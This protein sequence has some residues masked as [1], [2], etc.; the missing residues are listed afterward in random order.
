MKAL[1]L[2]ALTCLLTTSALAASPWDGT[3]KLDRSKSHLTGDSFTY[4]KTANGMW[5][6]SFGDLSYDFLPDGKPYP[7]LDADH[8]VTTTMNG[9][10]ALTMVS[11]FKGK[12]TST[13]KETLSADGTTLT[14]ASSGTRADGTSYTSSSTSKRSG[15]GTG[16]LGKWV[17]TKTSSSAQ[18]LFV[19]STAADGSVTMTYPGSKESLV[20]KLDG[21]P[22]SPTGPQMMQGVMVTYKKASPTRL[23][24]T[25][26]FKGK[27]IAEGYDVLSADGKT[28]TETSWAAGKMEE[29]TTSVYVKQ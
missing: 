19:I 1:Y 22:A 16:F 14:D 15:T 12:T 6:A 8:T 18:E 24:Y 5:H 4:S 10:H 25:V 28:Y 29:K 3:W 23:E 27:K 26:D 2:G 21:T 13:T 7:V 20:T 17:S 11:A 9:D